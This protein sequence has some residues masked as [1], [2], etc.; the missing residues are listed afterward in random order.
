MSFISNTTAAKLAGTVA[1][2]TLRATP[3]PNTV[4][5]GTDLSSL[6]LIPGLSVRGAVLTNQLQLA[7]SSVAPTGNN[8]GAVGAEGS[9]GN[10]GNIAGA[11]GNVSYNV[12]AVAAW[13]LQNPGLGMLA[14]IGLPVAGVLLYTHGHHMLGAAAIV[15]AAPLW[16]ARIKG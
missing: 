13:Q 15:A 4:R 9:D 5:P 10:A 7:G 3:P 6:A 16:Y 14:R 2:T 12:G 1:P 8:Y 11:Q